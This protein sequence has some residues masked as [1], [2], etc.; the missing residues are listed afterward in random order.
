MRLGLAP[1][2]I[3]GSGRAVSHPYEALHWDEDKARR[4]ILALHLD[5]KID[6][7]SEQPILPLELLAVSLPAFRWTPQSSGVR[8]P[9]HVAGP[10]GV[11]WAQVTTSLIHGAPSGGR[12]KPATGSKAGRS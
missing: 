10:L 5:L 3:I 6:Q 4:G 7:L 1:K 2:G 12:K 9:P 11:M 8:I